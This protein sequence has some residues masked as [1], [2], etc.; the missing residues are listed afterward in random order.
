MLKVKYLSAITIFL[1]MQASMTLAG[2]L[3][4]NIGVTNNYIWRGLTQTQNQ[5]AISGGIDFVADNGLYVGTWVS[6]VNYA[7]NDA[8]S[9]EN[10]IYFGYSGA[11][12]KLGY[13]L[14][15]LYY[16]YDDT[17]RFDFG[18]I[19]G[20]LSFAGFE[21]GGFLLANTEAD[22]TDSQDFDFG[23]TYYVYLDYT[24]DIKDGLELGFHIG[25]HDGDFNEAFNAVPG[26]YSDYNI[27]LSKSGFSFMITDTELKDPSA[28]GPDPLDNDEPK[29]VVSYSMDFEL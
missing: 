3:T 12:K 10:D 19:Y 2:D 1:M 24:I 20:N 7:P 27:S 18:E 13:D 29:F 8:F 16:N 15:Y 25:Y 11:V 21:L 4:A 9:Y 22:E 5:A 28:A 14:G 17:A 23:D 6:N 26:S